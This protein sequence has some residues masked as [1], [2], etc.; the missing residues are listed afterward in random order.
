MSLHPS[1]RIRVLVVDDEEAIRNVLCDVLS[2]KGYEVSQ[3]ASAQE[4][5]RLLDSSAFDLILSDVMMPGMTGLELAQ[6]VCARG[7]PGIV[8]LTGCDDLPTAV[9]AMKIG[10]LDYVTKPV[11]LKSLDGHLR[12]AFQKHKATIQESREL[13]SL[14]SEL[15]R[16]D[17]EI[18]AVLERLGDATDAVLEAL[19][20]ALDARA[21]DMHCHSK[22][23]SEYAVHL[24]NLLG[25]ESGAL[26]VLRQAALLHDI[27][28]IGIPDAILMKPGKLEEAEWDVMRKHHEIGA[29]ILRR[30]EALA[31]AAEIV[32]AHHERFDGTGYPLGL[33]GE[34][35]P[36]GAR[37]F[38]VAD[39][40]DV[41]T[42]GRL[43]REAQPFAAARQEIERCAGTHFDPN[44]VRGFLRVPPGDWTDIRAALAA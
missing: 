40:L 32:L 14:R 5:L 42:S 22:R 34:Q 41:V 17:R 18:D 11:N 7:G 25:M 21:H 23:V 9:G 33:R 36:F 3:A 19:G 10:A 28:K 15:D 8:M 26:R 12:D 44:V 20:A 38:A 31:P 35:I 27:G 13:T 24:G 30:I 39:C 2:Q 37:V 6:E 29:A 1:G 43:Y 16:K 4:A